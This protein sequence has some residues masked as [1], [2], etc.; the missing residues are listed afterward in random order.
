MSEPKD[1]TAAATAG[2]PRTQPVDGPLAAG[3][4][5]VPAPSAARPSVSCPSN[6]AVPE[7]AERPAREAGLPRRR[8]RAGVPL[9][10]V[11]LVVLAG[12]AS[13]LVFVEQVAGYSRDETP[14]AAPPADAIVVLTGGSE[15]VKV[16]LDLLAEGRAR[17]LLIS[18]VHPATT[19]RQIVTLTESDMALFSCCVDL[20][21]N[22]ANTLQNATEIT[23]WVEDNGYARVLVVTSAYHMPRALLELRSAA[24]G[25]TLL[26]VAVQ[27]AGMELERWYRDPAVSLLL[28][29]EHLKY[30]LAWLRIAV[31]SGRLPG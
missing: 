1:R 5:P 23:K 25:V 22:A 7:P 14:A 9:M 26:P 27:A 13:F 11:A 4:T 28:L 2:Q 10:L 18:G 6:T 20:D 30:M 21:R 8:W 15:R 31:A 3:G 16:A 29:R 12:L 19:P 17:R 24:A